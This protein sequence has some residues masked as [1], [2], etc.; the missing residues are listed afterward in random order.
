MPTSMLRDRDMPKNIPID[1]IF[2][3]GW[4]S[5]VEIDGNKDTEPYMNI[6]YTVTLASEIKVNY[7]TNLGDG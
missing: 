3:V 2:V 4:T 1:F 6:V 5:E 7:E